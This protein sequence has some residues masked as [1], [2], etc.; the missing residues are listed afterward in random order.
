MLYNIV[1]ASA[2]HQHE[3]AMGIRVS[4]PRAS[5]PRI[6]SLLSHSTAFELSASY[7]E[8]PLALYFTYDNVYI[9]VL[10]SQFIPPSASPTV[11]T[12]VLC[13]S[14]AALQIGSSA[15]LSR[16]RMYVLI[17]NICFSLSD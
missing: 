12:G 17:C 14:V 1:L 16:F 5:L 10:L 4:P 2:V 6:P 8:F 9:S 3:S 11:S 15:H 7:S 13:V